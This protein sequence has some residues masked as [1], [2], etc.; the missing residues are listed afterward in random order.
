MLNKEGLSI[1]QSTMHKR[2]YLFLNILVITTISMGV[3]ALIISTV[4]MIKG[5]YR[6]QINELEIKI[7]LEARA[8]QLANATNITKK[9]DAGWVE[10]GKFYYQVTKIDNRYMIEIKYYEMM[11]LVYYQIFDSRYTRSNY[12]YIIYEEGYRGA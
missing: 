4:T 11:N 10:D 2:G 8:L 5:H 7:L 9:L 6:K 1:L 12:E 3:F